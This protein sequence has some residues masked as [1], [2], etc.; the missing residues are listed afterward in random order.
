MLKGE[1]FPDP[2]LPYLETG[3]KVQV[4]KEG[5]AGSSQHEERVR[6]KK[7]VHPTVRKMKNGGITFRNSI[8]QQCTNS[9]MHFIAHTF[10][11]GFAVYPPFRILE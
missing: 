3:L 7:S 6:A 9:M 10:N 5:L 4:V 2:K 11:Y 8:S 1:K